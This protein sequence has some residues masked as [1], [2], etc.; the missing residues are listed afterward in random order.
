MR[1]LYRM[2]IVIKKEEEKTN[3]WFELIRL[4][5]RFLRVAS[6]LPW[7]RSWQKSRQFN[8]SQLNQMLGGLHSQPE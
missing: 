2:R 5:S 8:A 6:P 7:R 1:R 4:L 3:N